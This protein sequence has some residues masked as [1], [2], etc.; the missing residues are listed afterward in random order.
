MSA[1][2][3]F[4]S[5]IKT[6]IKRTP[7]RYII[8]VTYETEQQKPCKL[9]TKRVSKSQ[10]LTVTPDQLDIDTIW[11]LLGVDDSKLVDWVITSIQVI[12]KTEEI[13]Q[14][15]TVDDYEYSNVDVDNNVDVTV[16]NRVETTVENTVNANIT[17]TPN[18]RVT[19]LP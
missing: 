15:G 19:N 12:D 7:I 3:K 9:A 16:T 13:I 8:L 11:G 17:N 6:E 18:V 5:N 14:E 2:Q 10:I 1:S 4:V